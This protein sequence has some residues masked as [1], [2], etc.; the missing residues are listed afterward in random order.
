MAWT[1]MGL[2]RSLVY[3]RDKSI[4]SFDLNYDR[5]DSLNDR[6]IEIA[7]HT[8]AAAATATRAATPPTS[9]SQ[10]SC[11]TVRFVSCCL[12]FVTSFAFAAT[13]SFVVA[14]SSSLC[15]RFSFFFLLFFPFVSSHSK[16]VRGCAHAQY[17]YTHKINDLTKS[18]RSSNRQRNSNNTKTENWK[19]A[20]R[21]RNG[22]K[23]TDRETKCEF[24]A[25][26]IQLT[27]FSYVHLIH[28]RTRTNTYMHVELNPQID[29]HQLFES[30]NSLIATSHSLSLSP[31]CVSVLL[32]VY[33]ISLCVRVRLRIGFIKLHAHFK[34]DAMRCVIMSP[35]CSLLNKNVTFQEVCPVPSHWQ[36][37]RVQLATDRFE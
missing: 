17:A 32:S 13:S 36:F 34:F 7:E 29:Q 6:I 21:R 5:I 16:G 27:W 30:F 4:E 22:K 2:N 12:M 37:N 15:T 8:T 18:C 1:D 25:K 35:S 9:T 3:K 26:C 24:I 31:L 28:I 23:Y 33:T 20:K 10:K 11:Y 19:S 14:Y